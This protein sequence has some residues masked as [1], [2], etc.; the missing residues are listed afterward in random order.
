MAVTILPDGL[1]EVTGLS[2]VAAARYLAVCTAIVEEHAPGAPDAI[3]DEA[4]IRYAGYLDRTW[5]MLGLTALK[6]G[7]LH[8]EA[9]PD[10]GPSFRKSGAAA[11]LAQWVVRGWGLAVKS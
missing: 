5:S 8:L 6:D 2:A 11:L 7:E 4:V 3:Q 1:A 10:H 9:I